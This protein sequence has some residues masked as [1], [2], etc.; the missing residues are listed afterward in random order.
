MA[1]AEM[2]LR[3]DDKQKGKRGKVMTR[4]EMDDFTRKVR[5]KKGLK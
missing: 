3:D 5:A 4:K 1:Q 2:Y